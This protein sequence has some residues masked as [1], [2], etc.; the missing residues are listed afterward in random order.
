M[1][2]ETV[3]RLPLG[4]REPLAKRK[5]GDLV[6]GPRF[7]RRKNS[8]R[9]VHFLKRRQMQSVKKARWVGILHG[10]MPLFLGR[11]TLRLIGAGIARCRSLKSVRVMW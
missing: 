7:S 8:P 4:G 9:G 1:D 6:R 2:T 10:K 5:S 3:C 11:N